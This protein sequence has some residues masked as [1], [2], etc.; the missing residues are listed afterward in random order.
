MKQ[1]RSL[2]VKSWKRKRLQLK[3]Q[4]SSPTLDEEKQIEAGMCAEGGCFF[5]CRC[6]SYPPAPNFS[7]MEHNS[8][9][10]KNKTVPYVLT[11]FTL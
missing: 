7:I 11:Y 5:N 4:P 9:I 8:A 3:T 2:K 6:A 10:K 1:T